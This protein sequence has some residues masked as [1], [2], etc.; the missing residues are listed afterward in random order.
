MFAFY[1]PFSVIILW[2]QN[3]LAKQPSHQCFRDVYVVHRNN[4]VDSTTAY[5]HTETSRTSHYLLMRQLLQDVSAPLQ[6]SMCSPS[7][8]GSIKFT[9]SS[10][11]FFP[12][13][14]GEP[15]ATLSD[16]LLLCNHFYLLV[17][18]SGVSSQHCCITWRQ[19]SI[20][21]CTMDCWGLTTD[22]QTAAVRILPAN[23][24]LYTA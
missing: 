11:Q 4:T 14:H 15:E 13:E 20:F 10:S 5:V 19:R 1:L 8:L 3:D 12:N 17:I 9:V 2:T 16:S 6:R 22:Q 24:R 7:Q 21:V 23:I 18:C